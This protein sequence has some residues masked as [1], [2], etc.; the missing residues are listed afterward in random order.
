MLSLHF[1]FESDRDLTWMTR[2]L[3]DDNIV[4]DAGA[5]GLAEGLKYNTSL[6]TLYIVNLFSFS[7]FLCVV[8]LFVNAR[9]PGVDAV[10]RAATDS[11]H[12]A[13]VESYRPSSTTK[14]LPMRI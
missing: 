11:L 3:Q 9:C 14:I 6:K 2:T 5:F 12:L 13:F 10:C 7:V 1:S 4:G 8:V